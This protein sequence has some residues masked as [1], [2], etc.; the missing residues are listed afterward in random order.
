MNEW[1]QAVFSDNVSRRKPD[2][3][4]FAYG[5]NEVTDPDWTSSAYTQLY[6]DVIRRLKRAAP[7]A[8][9]LVWGPPEQGDSHPG[10]MAACPRNSGN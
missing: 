3:I 7:H 4:I 8:A 2:L 6:V 10:G 9:V 1:N 5:T